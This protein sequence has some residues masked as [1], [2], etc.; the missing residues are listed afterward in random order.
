MATIVFVP[1]AWH[2]CDAFIDV[3]TKVE[4]KGHHC[5][6]APLKTN[7]AKPA[8]KNNEADVERIRNIVRPLVE[9]GKDVV[10]VFHSYG[11]LPG[12]D[13]LPDLDKKSRSERGQNGGVIGLVYLAAFLLPAGPSVMDALGGKDLEWFRP[14]VSCYRAR[15]Y[16][17]AYSS[18]CRKKQVR[19]DATTLERSSTMASKTLKLNTGLTDW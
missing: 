18:T 6:P 1:G 5:V 10:M 15:F 3:M 2:N 11:S 8:L 14:D 19:W 9:E 7:G 4:A 13:A 16:P 17:Q 12:C